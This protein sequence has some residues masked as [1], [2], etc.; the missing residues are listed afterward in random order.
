MGSM[1]NSQ[2]I[3]LL[4]I[5]FAGHVCDHFERLAGAR[6]GHANANAS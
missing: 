5:S 3:A 1:S 6:D 4:V 2:D